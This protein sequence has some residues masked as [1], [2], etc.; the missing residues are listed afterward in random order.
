M[1][2]TSFRPGNQGAGDEVEALPDEGQEEELYFLLCGPA[3][4]LQREQDAAQCR[5]YF[6]GSDIIK[7]EGDFLDLGHPVWWPLAACG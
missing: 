2:S 3:F 5:Q 6:I 4:V 1:E 7:V